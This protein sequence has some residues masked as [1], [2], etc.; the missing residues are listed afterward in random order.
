MI[1]YAIFDMDGT[2][3][4]TEEMFRRSW[5]ITSKKYGLENADEVYEGVAGASIDTAK[6]LLVKNYGDRVNP[7]LFFKERTDCTLEMFEKEGIPIKKGCIELLQFL[8]EQQIP[9]VIATSTPMYITS[10]NVN[11]A[12]VREYFS[13]I[14]TAE[15]VQHGKPAPDIFL[16]AGKRIGADP[17]ETFV[18]EDSVNGVRGAYAAGMK[19]I[20]VFDRQYPDAE[21]K[22]L[23][24][25]ECESLLDIIDIIKRENNI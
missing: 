14:V 11:R 7:E 21:T 17:K 9:A 15:M 18:A 13:D 23:I 19:P 1:K 20:M 2:L 5:I 22:K 3:F 10:K 16:E 25:S 4:D 24:W 8:R 12:G 6:R